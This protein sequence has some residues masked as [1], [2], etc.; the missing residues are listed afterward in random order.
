MLSDNKIKEDP[1]NSTIYPFL[2]IILKNAFLF[3]ER[4]SFNFFLHLAV[5][6]SEGLALRE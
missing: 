3:F 2:L 4:S 6:F 5:S 1:S